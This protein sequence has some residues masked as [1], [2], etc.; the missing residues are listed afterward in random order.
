MKHALGRTRNILFAAAITASM[1]FGA[2]QA[3]ASSRPA[4]STP[5]KSCRDFQ[6]RTAC[7]EF[8]GTYD[9]WR[10]ICLCCG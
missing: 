8:G 9:S 10:R 6:C 5:A 2:T 7:G 4:E 3:L 1:G